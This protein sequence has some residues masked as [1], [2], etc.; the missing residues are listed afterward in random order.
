MKKFVSDKIE[1]RLQ[2][3]LQGLSE[4][5]DQSFD[6]AICD[7]PYGAATSALRCRYFS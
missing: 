1:L 3:A 6:L 2:D 7:P 4:L 5:D